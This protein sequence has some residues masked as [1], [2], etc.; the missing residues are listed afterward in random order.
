MFTHPSCSSHIMPS[1][2]RDTKA[3]SKI[4]HMI[5]VGLPKFRVR[6]QNPSDESEPPRAT[7]VRDE[8][9]Q[10]VDS[11]WHIPSPI[12]G[13]WCP[14]A[15]YLSSDREVPSCPFMWAGI[16]PPGFS[17]RITVERHMKSPGLNL[18]RGISPCLVLWRCTCPNWLSPPNG[19]PSSTQIL[20]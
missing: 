15:S 12:D 20:T 5:T 2:P 9:T 13:T 14:Q 4:G 1:T 7:R 6:R 8:A 19:D 16:E 10:G 17:T 18:I 3:V 11:S